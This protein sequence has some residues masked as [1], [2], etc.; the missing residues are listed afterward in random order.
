MLSTMGEWSADERMELMKVY[1]S[2]ACEIIENLQDALLKLEAEPDSV[3]TL[4]ELK[5]YV[6]TLKGDSGSVGL[7][8]I[9]DLCHRME[10]VLSLFT[11]NGD[12]D[13]HGAVDLLLSCTDALRTL[14]AKT[15][16]GEDAGDVEAI[17]CRINDFLGQ[18]ALKPHAP[19]AIILSEYQELQ[20]Q[21][22]VKGGL[23]VYE[24]EVVFHP[25]CGEKG[26][27]ARMALQRLG[28]MGHII[29][30]FPDIETKGIESAKMFTLV[31]ATDR[32]AEEI[33]RIAVQTG[34]INNVRI[35]ERRSDEF[36]VQGSELKKRTENNPLRP[37]KLELRSE[38]LRIEA[39]RVN[40][41]VN[42]VGELII[43]RSMV[44]QVAKEIGNAGANDVAMRLRSINA[45]LE[46][47]VSD[48]RKGVMKMRMV[49]VN[50]VF[51]KFPRMV[52]DLSIE[53]GKSVRID[54]VGKETELDKGI[55][56][57][58]GE[59]LA[60]I[61][62]NMIDHGIETPDQ[63][64][65]A[66]KPAEGVIIVRAYHEA[67]QIIIEAS[68]DGHG[69]DTE[70]LKRRATEK[71]FLG[72]DEAVKMT[73]ADAVRLIFRPGLST[74]EVVTDTSGRGV[75][76]DAVKSAVENMRGS[77]DIA[78]TPGTER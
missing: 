53:K 27:A 12:G 26:I 20:L 78:S 5:R 25:E 24:V 15:E 13:Q 23:R 50:Q 36:G 74:A 30:C 70:K 28:N 19:M 61:I 42:L 54:I 51:R 4:R 63:R 55:V 33:T 75:G 76:M 22:A 21:E 35:R 67:A 11:E 17:I 18:T 16:T 43:G 59:P 31:F 69:I 73:D 64:R 58:L 68:D 77:I 34:F 7:T 2:G 1:Y 45:Y 41:L 40:Q 49:R 14:L 44:D 57:N 9:G 60:H 48:L 39:S 46:R 65:S 47:K 72:A 66:G 52:R 37:P 10:D 29:H 71:G 38:F 3:D 56:D 32:D 62:R 8:S 6:H